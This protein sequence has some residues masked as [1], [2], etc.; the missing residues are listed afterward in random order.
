[1]EV[2]HKIIKNNSFFILH[3]KKYHKNCICAVEHRT[4]SST[5]NL[6]IPLDPTMGYVLTT[7]L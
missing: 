7:V 4:S 6:H 2:F 5:T 1:M 3:K